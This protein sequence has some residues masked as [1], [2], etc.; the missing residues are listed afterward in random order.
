MRT[1]IPISYILKIQTDD[2]PECS[3]NIFK[4]KLF[5][6]VSKSKFYLKR[7]NTK[8]RQIVLTNKHNVLTIST[9]PSRITTR[10]VYAHSFNIGIT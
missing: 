6:D 10:G 3:I 8:L 1:R 4:L 5:M 9:D 2:D 7:K